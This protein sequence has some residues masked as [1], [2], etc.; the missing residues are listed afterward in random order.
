[1]P[2]QSKHAILAAVLPL[3]DIDHNLPKNKESLG[4]GFFIT[5][6]TA[7]SGLSS[8]TDEY[9]RSQLSEAH[10]SRITATDLYLGVSAAFPKDS[11]PWVTFQKCNEKLDRFFPIAQFERE[12][13]VVPTGRPFWLDQK[14]CIKKRILLS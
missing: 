2:R 8:F 9:F 5:D 1:M 11:D 4:N 14:G 12:I 6:A 13:M 10:W 7:V 3:I